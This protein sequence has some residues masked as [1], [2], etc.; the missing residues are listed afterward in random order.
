[1]HD[2]FISNIIIFDFSFLLQNLEFK[3]VFLDLK[4]C[5][6]LVMILSPTFLI[7]LPVT[8]ISF[9]PCH[10]SLLSFFPL[11][12]PFLDIHASNSLTDTVRWDPVPAHWLVLLWMGAGFLLQLLPPFL[13]RTPAFSFLCLFKDRLLLK[14]LLWKRSW[15]DSSRPSI[16][17]KPKGNLQT[18][19]FSFSIHIFPWPTICL[20]LCWPWDLEMNQTQSLPSVSSQ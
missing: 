19:R 6:E 3:V 1:M 13:P 9:K 2:W 5:Y 8:L 15:K 12:C 16:S 18:Q 11:I 4:T 14:W 10:I 7:S 17:D 20:L